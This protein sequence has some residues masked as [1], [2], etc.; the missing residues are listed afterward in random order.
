[1]S[2]LRG[3]PYAGYRDT[4]EMQALLRAC[5]LEADYDVVGVGSLVD[6]SGGTASW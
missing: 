2:D 1:M 5:E 3:R 6:R 4:A